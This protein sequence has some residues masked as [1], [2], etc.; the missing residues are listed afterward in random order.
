[1]TR[2]MTLCLGA[3]VSVACAASQAAAAAPPLKRPAAL[4]AV[5]DCGKI[6]EDAERL[7]CFDAAVAKMTEAERSGDLVAIDRE[8]RRAVTRQSF[9]FTLPSLAVFDRGDKSD[10]A[11]KLTATLASASRN[12]DNKWVFRLQDGAV[13]RQIDDNYL[14][15]D[16]HPGSAIVIRRAMLGSY[17]LN[18]DGQPALRVHR[19]N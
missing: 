13:W 4:Q 17:I 14:G 8:Q 11:D 5:V 10:E 16:P 3:A 12:A 7:K 6:A 9:G 1:M 2:T 19:D 18:V 15:R